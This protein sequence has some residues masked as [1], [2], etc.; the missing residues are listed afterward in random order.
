[1]FFKSQEGLQ[2]EQ[3]WRP[4]HAKQILTTQELKHAQVFFW[5]IAK[6]FC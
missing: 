6:K 1:M 4:V 5:H 3:T 2:T